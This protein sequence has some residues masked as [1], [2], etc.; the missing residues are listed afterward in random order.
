M[1]VLLKV[2]G[3]EVLPGS[4]LS[5]TL[6]LHMCHGLQS[7]MHN[8]IARLHSLTMMTSGMCKPL[9]CLQT[10]QMQKH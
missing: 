5:I 1:I 8:N 6:T 2:V 3:D 7:L 4:N 10:M 9:M